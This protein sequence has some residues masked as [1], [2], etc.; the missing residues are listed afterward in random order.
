MFFISKL[1]RYRLHFIFF[2]F[3]SKLSCSIDEENA[4]NII[5]EVLTKSKVIESLV[6]SR[7]VWVQFVVQNKTFKNQVGLYE[8]E[9][10]EST[11][12]LTI[13]IDPK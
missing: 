4:R 8:A 5:F 13:T 6:L 3:I 11:N 10:I 1:N 12:I 9:N 7:N 2:V